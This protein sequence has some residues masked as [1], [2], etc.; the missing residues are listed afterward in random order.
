MKRIILP[1]LLFLLFLLVHN[2]QSYGEESAPA[3][4]IETYSNCL[5]RLISRYNAKADLRNSSLDF[6]SP[7]DPPGINFGKPWRR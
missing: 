5:E 3:K 4:T 1:V 2:P 7:Q 6:P